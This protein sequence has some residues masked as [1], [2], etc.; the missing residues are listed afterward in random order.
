MRSAASMALNVLVPGAGLV[1]VG[2]ERWGTAFALL[3]C[4]LGQVALFGTWITP[5][6]LPHAMTFAAMMGV[7]CVWIAAQV[8]LAGRLSARRGPGLDEEKSALIELAGEALERGIYVNAR[9]ALESALTL[10]DE[11]VTVNVLWARLMTLTGRF[12]EARRA[13]RRVQQLDRM[14]ESGREAG[15]ALRQLPTGK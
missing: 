10:D 12:D 14:G 9:L 8:M 4:A 2:R 13:W 3:F 5:A 7:A 6:S 1:L 11:D 15:E